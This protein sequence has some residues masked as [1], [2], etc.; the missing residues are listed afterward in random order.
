VILNRL[1]IAGHS[2]AYDL[3]EPL[4]AHRRDPEIGRRALAKLSH[5]IALD[6]TYG[7]DVEA[8][9]D[10]LN[11][12]PAL[13]VHV[14]YRPDSPTAPIGEEFFRRRSERLRVIKADEA[15]CSVPA[16]RLAE[17]LGDTRL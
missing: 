13:V 1:F 15:H 7:G 6:S 5:V 3:L 11:V 14:F 4:A 9:T 12:N 10:W 16:R 17:V 2:R 8:W